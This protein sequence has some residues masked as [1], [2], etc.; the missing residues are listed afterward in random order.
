MINVIIFVINVNNII[1]NCVFFLFFLFKSQQLP[2]IYVKR[3][4]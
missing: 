2:V 4:L 1:E 3:S